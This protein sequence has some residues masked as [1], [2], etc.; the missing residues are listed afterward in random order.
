M[1]IY[2]LFYFL[3]FNVIVA[4]ISWRKIRKEKT[5]TS[6]GF[7]LGKRNLNFVL[8]GSLLLLSNINGVQFIGENES[9]YTNNMTVMA[10]G[11]TSIVAMLIVSEFFMPIYL[12]SGIITTPDFLEERYDIGTKKFVSIIFLLSYIVNMLP[13]VLYGGAVIF[14]GIFDFSDILGISNFAMMWILVWS[15][16]LIGIIYTLV[17]GIKVIAISDALLG[18]G[19]LV[20]GL[21]LP[22]FGLK[23]LGKGN[24]M[25]GVNIILS[26]KTEHFNAIGTAK[27]AIPFSTLFTGMLLVNLNYWGMEQYIV[28]RTLASKNLAESQKGITL[29]AVGK[30]LAPLIINIPG[31][32]AVHLYPTI[33]NTAEIFPRL[34]GDVLPSI[35][36]GLIASVIFGA[37]ITS[38]NAGLNSIS[39]LF[40]LNIYKPSYETRQKP[41]TDE[42]LIKIGR[43]FQIFVALLA[44]C[45]APFIMFAKG[46]FYNYLQK[47]GG[48][49]SVPIFT[50]LI[51][52]FLTKKVPPL[53]AK[54]GLTFFVI[55][56]VLSQFVF[57]T[58]LHFLH[59]LAILFIITVIIM[60]IIGKIQPM[61]IPY[62][63]KDS[64][65]V[66]L[67]PWKNRHI[68][69]FILIVLMTLVYI[70]FS[71]WGI[72]QH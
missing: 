24:F 9:V 61:E 27:D 55:C 48:A 3:L 19:L 13:T 69:G 67:E 4:I 65:K 49:F 64:H 66:N 58:G 33:N 20:G 26:S 63:Q 70:L 34:A 15:F 22:Y 50:V 57:D 17:G 68:Y 52:G 8:V 51:V 29:A 11:M 62:L 38:F 56:Y 46:G 42:A 25:E 72:V 53:A 12:R 44:M 30:L 40:V 23:Y 6:E 35:L 45:I 36:I 47:V 39:T 28:Q 5:I 18:V 10:W 59:V 54:V 31:I 7:F 1:N 71:K 37:A 32:I 2:A 14:N 60:L 16:G 43:R 41:L 21:F